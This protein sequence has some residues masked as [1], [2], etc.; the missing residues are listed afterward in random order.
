MLTLEKQT[1]H[2]L[3]KLYDVPLPPSPSTAPAPL[4]THLSTEEQRAYYFPF[5]AGRLNIE[6]E[7]IPFCECECGDSRDI[8]TSS[9]LVNPAWQALPQEAR[10]Y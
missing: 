6:Q 5:T 2:A 9:A 4:P 1:F 10:G 3:P 8:R 7:R